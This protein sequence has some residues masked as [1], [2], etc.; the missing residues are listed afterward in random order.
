M[1]GF[2]LSMLFFAG[3]FALA[4]MMIQRKNAKAQTIGDHALT[5]QK[6]KEPVY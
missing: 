3:C 6:L 5:Q 1:L 2:D 4:A